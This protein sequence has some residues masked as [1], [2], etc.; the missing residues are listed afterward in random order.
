MRPESRTLIGESRAHLES[1]GESY[2]AH[3]R[4]AFLVG[5]SMVKAGFACIIHGLV[6]AVFTD[7]ASRTIRRLH[8]LIERRELPAEPA[9]RLEAL[10]LLAM[11]SL[12]VALLPWIG[13][14]PA[15][16]ALPLTLLSLAFLPAYWWSERRGDA[17]S[18]RGRG[19][20]ARAASAA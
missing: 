10:P 1:V 20:S 7:T 11:L 3:R 17:P 16:A 6:P 18:S 2:A 12:T 8:A 19:L 5:G 14:A 9:R 15:L 4:F 13:G